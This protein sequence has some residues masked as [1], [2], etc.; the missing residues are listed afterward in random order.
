M[1]SETSHVDELIEATTECL[2][3]KAPGKNGLIR[4]AFLIDKG[5]WLE[6]NK[7]D[8]IG[9]HLTY[10][11][12]AQESMEFA[13]RQYAIWKR[14]MVD[15]LPHPSHKIPLPPMLE[16]GNVDDFMHGLCVLHAIND[17]PFWLM[18][19]RDVATRIVKRLQNSKGLFVNVRLPYLRWTLPAG[20]SP[21]KPSLMKRHYCEAPSNGLVAEKLLLIGSLTRDEHLLTAG[22]R[23]LDAWLGTEMYRKHG[24]FP[25]ETMP[26]DSEK[27][28]LMKP[29]SNLAFALL[30][31]AR[32]GNAHRMDTVL[33]HIDTLRESFSVDGGLTN[34]YDP[35]IGAKGALS[36]IGTHAFC[37]L[38]MYAAELGH[39]EL[40][41][42]AES[43]A[44]NVLRQ[45]ITPG[46]SWSEQFYEDDGEGD[47]AIIVMLLDKDKRHA[48]LLSDV[49]D[50]MVRRFYL[51]AGMWR[52]YAGEGR[53]Q[54]AH[55]KFIGGVL[56]YLLCYRA[57]LQKED[58]SRRKWLFLLQDR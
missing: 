41:K 24:L 56:K 17:D 44:P 5:E 29:N 30:Q 14:R 12:A 32:N 19:A 58:L 40:L 13:K 8:D 7:P 23:C 53:Q 21:L 43:L 3:E 35:R 49:F 2:V 11:A 55:T 52:D 57:Y 1:L 54:T 36:L 39:P 51:G 34:E 25:D 48:K 45:G 31:S 27:T 33:K 50:D 9:D 46:S 28:H 10:I 26:K 38:L 15:G 37:R 4:K 22:E 6:F 20:F 18:E 47:F 16:I 42:E